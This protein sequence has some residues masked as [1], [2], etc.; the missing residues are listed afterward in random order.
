MFRAS[1]QEQENA[2]VSRMEREINILSQ[3]SVG[4]SVSISLST[5]HP[6]FSSRLTSLVEFLFY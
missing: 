5:F 3:T 4:S 1:R 2:K 6:P